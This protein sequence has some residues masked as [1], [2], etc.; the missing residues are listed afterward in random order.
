[1]APSKLTVEFRILS[2]INYGANLQCFCNVLKA[3]IEASK[4]S[5]FK[6]SQPEVFL[7]K[8]VLKIYRT[9]MTKCDFNKVALQ[10]Y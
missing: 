1:M 3:F 5:Y 6:N 7:G 8:R 10:L 9:P 2:S 4:F